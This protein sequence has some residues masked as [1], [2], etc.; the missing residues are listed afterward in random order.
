V[1]EDAQDAGHRTS[2]AWA[3]VAGEESGY[4]V[5]VDNEGLLAL[6]REEGRIVRMALAIGDF[7]VE[8]EPLAY[9]EGAAPASA[10]TRAA[11][12][13]CYSLA[14][15]RTIQQDAPFGM[16][17][18]VD[19]GLKALSP[20]INDQSTAVMCIDRLSELLVH[21]A[22]RRIETPLRRNGEA[23]RVIARGPTF[24]GLLS[25]AVR[26]LCEAG[27]GKPAVLRRLLDALQR[28]GAATSNAGRRRALVEEAA[29][30]AECA[31]RTVQPPREREAL[32]VEANRLSRELIAPAP[33]EAPPAARRARS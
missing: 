8:G 23:L 18:I 21:L 3:P 2:G 33:P 9:L 20:G 27:G 16:Q 29:R 5:T 22:R 6:A 11:L 25:L 15:Q 10:K 4:I 24:A 30:V 31:A 32:L 28:V 14:A 12:N 26:D 7:A 19:V 17:E 13:R 1:D